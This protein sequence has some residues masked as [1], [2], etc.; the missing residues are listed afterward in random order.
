MKLFK[1]SVNEGSI[2]DERLDDAVRRI[3]KAKYKL[4]LFENP[5]TDRSYIADFGSYKHRQVAREAV[6]H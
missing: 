1:E 2:K 6:R 3:L 5:Y 4:G